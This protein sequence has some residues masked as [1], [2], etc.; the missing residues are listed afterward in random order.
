MG[1]FEAEQHPHVEAR[2]ES[3]PVKTINVAVNGHARVGRFNRRLA[4]AITA[5]VGTMWCA[6]TFA[7][8]A[9]ISLPTSLEHGLAATIAWI[10][11]TFLQLVLLSIILV[12][13]NVQS[14]ASDKQ[15]EQTYNDAEAILLAT[16]EIHR[17]LDVQDDLVQEMHAVIVDKSKGESNANA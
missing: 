6:Y 8:L 16:Q 9:I 3:G 13:Q 12:A 14:E 17:H 4:V 1:F 15:A 2:K 7:L 5:V 11:Q 10:A